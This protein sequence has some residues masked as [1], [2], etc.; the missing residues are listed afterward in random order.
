MAVI[1]LTKSYK[2]ADEATLIKEL[3]EH[4]KK[5]TAPYKYPRKVGSIIYYA[6]C[7]KHNLL[8]LC[9]VNTH[10]FFVFKIF[11]GENILL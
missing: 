8:V 3:Q 7:R 4:V 2:T 5:T 11:W 6:I 1:M 9:L 10:V